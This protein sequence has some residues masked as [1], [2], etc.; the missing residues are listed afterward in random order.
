MRQYPSTPA[1]QT[2]PAAVAAT[3]QVQAAGLARCI[4]PVACSESPTPAWLNIGNTELAYVEQGRGTAIVFIHGGGGDWRTWE[5]LRPYIAA[6]HR[7]VSYSRRYHHPN[8]PSGAGTAYTVPAQADDL[9]AFILALGAGPVHAVGGS[10]GARVLLEAAVN[11][12]ELFLTVAASE[13]FITPPRD[14]AAVAAAKEL[15]E[16]LGGIGPAMLAGGPSAA[17]V[18]LV[19]AVTGDPEGWDRL[20]PPARQRFTDNDAA[21]IAL[22]EAPPL[23]PTRCEA[24]GKLP[25]P[26]MVMEGECTLAG[27]RVTN[28][29]LMECLPPGSA[30]A[31]VPGAP[32]MWYGVNPEAAAAQILAF[33]KRATP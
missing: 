21:W 20:A 16:A 14:P 22:A 11:R 4:A 30:R 31:V 27:F 32:H 5:P 28:D 6:S 24:L 1:L 29:R 9:V 10:Y 23:A 25:M 12:P 2:H 19:K 7:F 33:V 26:V 18:Q 8:D 15:S 13:A 17:T 3:D